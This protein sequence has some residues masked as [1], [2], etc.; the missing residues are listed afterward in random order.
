MKKALIILTFVTI[1]LLA[2]AGPVQELMV[3]A[4]SAFSKGDYLKA[5]GY[6]VDIINLQSATADQRDDA[7]YN[8]NVC[9]NHINDAQYNSGYN[10]ALSLF[11]EKKFAQSR[12][13]CISLLKYRK[14]KPKTNKLIHQCNDSINAR[15][16]AQQVADSIQQLNQ[17]REEYN[18]IIEEAFAYY[19]NKQYLNAIMA[20]REAN[21]SKYNQLGI[22]E[23]A[24]VDI[25]RNIYNAQQRGEAV[26]PE[27]ASVVR[28]AIEIN[29]FSSGIARI[30]TRYEAGLSSKSDST[31][32]V[33]TLG[34]DILT[35][36][37]RPEYIGS[38]YNDGFLVLDDFFGGYYNQYGKFFGRDE[39]VGP[40]YN[41][42]K[43]KSIE[44]YES[45][46]DGMGPFYMERTNRGKGK[47]G[48]MDK[49]LKVKILPQY[50]FVTAFSEGY[51]LVRKKDK[52]SFI[53]MNGNKLNL[54]VPIYIYGQERNFY[55]YLNQVKSAYF[56]DGLAGFWTKKDQFVF[57]NYEGEIVLSLDNNLAQMITLNNPKGGNS[58]PFSDGLI[59][60]YYRDKFG[61]MDKK[62]EITIPLIYE[63]TYGFNEGLAAIKINDKWGFIDKTGNITIEPAFD[64]VSREG[65]S[66]GLC[67]VK[68]NGK[69]GYVDE[70]G[71]WEIN[72]IYDCPYRI[73]NGSVG[74]FH[75]GFA[76]VALNG[77][78]G[79]VD[80][81]G[82]STF[83]F[84]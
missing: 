61:F 31:H 58:L 1:T 11:K 5:K 43:E 49:N 68:S 10:H 42:L 83:D 30:V 44:G 71:K 40:N 64:D 16:I 81:F 52:W 77:Q 17:L 19:N 55:G 3:L 12:N 48:Y 56:H 60:L 33:N 26:T 54:A 25:C 20:I 50:D 70:S 62:G 4:E 24:W 47:W 35:F 38:S 45:F 66:E 74:S 32:F 18:S 75:N 37:G 2:F 46:S 80:K 76:A 41:T 8:I 69:W 39:V 65:F 51:A 57:I 67:A 72:P 84:Q 28:N 9:Q 6:Y 78:V 21:A 79:Y 14:Y 82:N 15:A 29:D 22:K 13:I 34:Y 36:K 53:D 7:R 23:P 59:P 73:V 63:L 27:L